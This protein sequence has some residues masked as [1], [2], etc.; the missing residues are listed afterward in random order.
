MCVYKFIEQNNE[1]IE[2]LEG[3]LDDEGI[4]TVYEGGRLTHYNVVDSKIIGLN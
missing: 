1:N 3:N 4:I 2:C